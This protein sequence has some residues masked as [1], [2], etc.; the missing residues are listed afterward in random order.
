[1]LLGLAAAVALPREGGLNFPQGINRSSVNKN[2]AVQSV[3]EWGQPGVPEY[4]DIQLVGF[5]QN[6][7]VWKSLYMLYLIVHGKTRL[8]LLVRK[9]QYI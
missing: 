3:C 7:S 6:A 5:Y 8:N 4:G 2:V 1:M 9:N